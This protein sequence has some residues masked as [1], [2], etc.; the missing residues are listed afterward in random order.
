MKRPALT[1]R[2]FN[3][4]WFPVVEMFLQSVPAQKIADH[5][6]QVYKIEISREMVY[7]IAGQA[8]Q[9][10][11]MFVT[12]PRHMALSNHLATFPNRGLVDVVQGR[13]PAV[14]DYV[15]RTAAALVLK[16]IKE[17]GQGRPGKAVHLGIGIGH[18]TMHFVHWLTALMRSDPSIPALVVHALSTAYSSW[19][20]LETPLASFSAFSDALRDVKF[21]GLFAQPWV[22]AKEYGKLKKH[23]IIREAFDR[24]H[25]IDIVVTSLGASDHEHGYLSNYVH[26]FGPKGAVER[27]KKEDWVGDVQLRPYSA[28]GPIR[29]ESGLKPVTLFELVDLVNMVQCGKKVV[30][31]CGPCGRCE[32]RKVKALLPLLQQPSLKLWSHLVVDMETAEDVIASPDA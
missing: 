8:A 12:P 3:E 27:L 22:D 5:I 23:D 18:T 7:P 26:K 4:V 31:M 20:P 13:G 6:L 14:N 30:L 2:E 28:S 24:A 17:I 1:D 29:I 9:R 11:F 15:T 32:K 16:L 25:E 10:K 19:D 21:V